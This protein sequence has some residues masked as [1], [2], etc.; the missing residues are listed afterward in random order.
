MNFPSFDNWGQRNGG[1]DDGVGSNNNLSS[2]LDSNAR[3]SK[4]NKEWRS[5][6]ILSS[7]ND[8]YASWVMNHKGRKCPF[9]KLFLATEGSSK[10]ERFGKRGR[11]RDKK[12]RGGTHHLEKEEDRVPTR[13]RWKTGWRGDKNKNRMTRRQRQDEDYE[14]GSNHCFQ[15]SLAHHI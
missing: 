7:S 15:N 4:L 10:E 14:D 6:T 1:N 2:K 13:Q 12:I 5:M 8:I 11:N 3:R 9:N